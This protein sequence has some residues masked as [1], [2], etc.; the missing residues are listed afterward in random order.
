M[1]VVIRTTLGGARVLL[2]SALVVFGLW[3]VLPNLLEA[4]PPD[5][6]ALPTPLS[7]ARQTLAPLASAP[8]VTAAPAIHASTA[9]TVA[10]TDRD[11]T[12]AAE[13]YFPQTYAGMTLQSPSVRVTSGRVIFT[14]SARTFF[15]S[16]PFVANAVPTA[17]DGRVVLRV[18]SATLAGVSLPESMRAQIAQQLQAAIDAYTSARVRVTEV[19]TGVGILTLKGTAA[20]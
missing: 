2:T 19:T 14:A 9:M 15:G 17:S 1:G 13:P 5:P 11:L 18:E 8:A 6:L 12:R 16:S 7:V 4:R 20:P 10:L 3:S